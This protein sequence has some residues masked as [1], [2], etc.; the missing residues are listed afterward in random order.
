[1][2][3]TSYCSRG[4]LHEQAAIGVDDPDSPVGQVRRQVSLA[5]RQDQRVEFDVVNLADIVF[6]DFPRR[7]G[8]AAGNQQH[9]PS[10]GPLRHCVM[11]GLLDVLVI[12][13]RGERDAVLNEINT[14]RRTRS[15]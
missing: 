12:A 3:A 8:D 11:H 2:M 6:E 15:R 5:E 13:R 14:G 9:L 1:M 10:L 4:L 7:A